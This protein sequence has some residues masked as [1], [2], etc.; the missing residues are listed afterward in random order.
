[1]TA[2]LSSVNFSFITRL[3]PCAKSLTIVDEITFVLI[4]LLHVNDIALIVGVHLMQLFPG[5]L[6]HWDRS[7]LLVMNTWQILGHGCAATSARCVDFGGRKFSQLCQRLLSLGRLCYR[8]D[9][10]VENAANYRWLS[11]EIAAQRICCRKGRHGAR[12]I[13]PIT[14]NTNFSSCACSYPSTHESVWT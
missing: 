11:F 4:F 7:V 5:L 8:S 13:G 9:F 14:S 3:P 2:F 10:S 1:M 6:N 12:Y